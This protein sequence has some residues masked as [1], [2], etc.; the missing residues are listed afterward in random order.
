MKGVIMLLDI[1]MTEK[2]IMDAF[3]KLYADHPIDKISIKMIMESAGFNR[4]TFYLHY[5]DIYDL[6]EKVEDI[7]TGQLKDIGRR[8][9]EE[10]VNE[11][12]LLRALPE[13][14]F[15]EN[16]KEYLKVLLTIPGKSQ[17]PEM[18]KKELKM[19]L[20]DK[21]D[22]DFNQDTFLIYALEYLTSAQLAVIT[23]WIKDDMNVPLN[24][25]TKFMYNI[26]I[27]GGIEYLKNNYQEA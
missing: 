4:G 10:L 6:R 11:G 21:L 23:Q 14:E 26:S 8:V 16:T 19:A 9:A 18:M 1:N 25:V 5:M 7:F 15:Y 12:N 2:K 17:L 3:M 22:L 24:E 20:L 27:T 13:V